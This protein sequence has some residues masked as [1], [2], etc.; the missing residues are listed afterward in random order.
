MVSVGKCQV[1]VGNRLERWLKQV[2]ITLPCYWFMALPIP[3]RCAGSR[4]HHKVDEGD[5][6]F[7]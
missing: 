1:R 7:D 2:V 4:N 6:G 3:A 5:D